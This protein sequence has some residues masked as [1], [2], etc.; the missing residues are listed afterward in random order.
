MIEKINLSTFE[1]TS[2]TILVKIDANYGFVPIKTP[3]GIIELQIVYDGKD[4]QDATKHYSITGAV[5]SIPKEL[6]YFHDKHEHSRGNNTYFESAMRNS[7]QHLVDLGLE[8]GNQIYFNYKNQMD[9]EKE[10]RIVETDKYGLCMLIPYESIYAKKIN[11]EILPINGW[12]FFIRDKTPE[13]ITFKSGIIGIQKENAY[14]SNIG[15]VTELDKP[16]KRY[17]D[18]SYE[19]KDNLHK[20]DRIIIQK[21]YGYKLA[22]PIHNKEIKDVEVVRRKNIM[23]KLVDTELTA[24]DQYGF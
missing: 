13:Q 20:G 22:Y 14:G 23:G 7:M 17:L 16:V 10:S 11:E 21:G 1:L 6:F 8:I 3:S 12:V 5:V 9:A 19:P 24:Q 18:G 4:K 2:N 15:T